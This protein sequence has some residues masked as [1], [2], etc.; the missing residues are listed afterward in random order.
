MTLRYTN[1]LDH[2][3]S[4]RQRAGLEHLLARLAQGVTEPESAESLPAPAVLS[5]EPE[6]P[7]EQVPLA[8][9]VGTVSRFSDYTRRFNPLLDPEAVRLG[10]ITTAV[11]NLAGFPPVD[12]YR[13][14]NRYFVRDGNMRVALA[15]E[16]GLEMIEARV[17]PI[18]SRITLSPDDDPDTL[19]SKSQYAD[20]L[21]A[22]NLDRMRPGAA[23]QMRVPGHYGAILAQ[24][25][26]HHAWMRHDSRRDDVPYP[27]AV[28]DWYD[29]LYRPLVQLIREHGLQHSFPDYTDAD[30]YVLVARYYG[31]LAHRLGWEVGLDSAI[32][33]FVRERNQ[34]Q[35]QLPGRIGEQVRDLFGSADNTPAAPDAPRLRLFRDILIAGE[36]H[37]A[38]LSALDLA[39]W[40]AQ[41]EHSRLFGL[42]VVTSADQGDSPLVEQLTHTFMQ[43]AHRVGVEAQAAVVF[44][45]S[46]VD[47]VVGRA[48][49]ADLVVL[50][51]GVG[52]AGQV[53][54]LEAVVQRSPRPLLLVPD[55]AE[56]EPE[57]LL[58]AY[59]DSDKAREA[60]WMAAWMAGHWG[61]QLVVL[62]A[63]KRE[64]AENALHA[65][66]T[67]LKAREI[68]ARYE[69]RPVPVIDAILD[70]SQIYQIQLL[71]MGGF[72]R[73]PLLRT[74]LGSVARHMVRHYTRPLLICR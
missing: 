65:A 1:A 10:K 27:D 37:L 24:I 8:Q 41:R 3:R 56:T 11:H 21:Q 54:G 29:N 73:K 26:R 61:S 67:R 30:L 5:A 46:V 17:T 60:L 9:I 6:R 57:R 20:F 32:A 70:V 33:R 34:A 2:F 18:S 13:I 40:I 31:E 55:G 22:T 19:I 42:H 16:L 58:L 4:A 28:V 53:A 74:G 49:W 50:R 68:S 69:L 36:G 43:R 35:A 66:R 64:S 44:N 62:G 52:R 72:G 63:G 47:E 48:A 71:I 23:L 38:E 25:A 7:V 45:E 12:L 39:L 15:R 51:A 59:D 14:G